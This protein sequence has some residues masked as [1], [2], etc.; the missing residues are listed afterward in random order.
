MPYP[1]F[2][3]PFLKD[4]KASDS[5]LPLKSEIILEFYGFQTDSDQKAKATVRIIRMMRQRGIARHDEKITVSHNFLDSRNETYIVTVGQRNQLFYL[6]IFSD[7][8][9]ALGEE[10]EGKIQPNEPLAYK[11]LEYSGFSPKTYLLIELGSDVEDNVEIYKENYIMTEDLS[12]GDCEFILAA[13]LK[14]VSKINK[15]VD[16][17]EFAI[18]LSAAVLVHDFL[19]LSDSLGANHKN[20]GIVFNKKEDTF[21]IQFIDHMPNA[22]NGWFSFVNRLEERKRAYSPRGVFSERQCEGFFAK[23]AAKSKRAIDSSLIKKRVNARVFKSSD[24]FM[25]F[26]S[27]LDRA[28]KEIEGEIKK[29]PE[30]FVENP[31]EKMNAYCEKIRK[32]MSIFQETEYAQRVIKR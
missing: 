12:Q 10:T 26:P 7:D 31:L 23:L 15:I 27:A 28:Q 14:E 8:T 1:D 29:C 2:I 16:T 19:C 30:N 20:Y 6:K 17:P 18:N 25:D 3:L 9:Y 11:A 32:N 21:S 13:D 24:Q 4:I 5:C 22:N